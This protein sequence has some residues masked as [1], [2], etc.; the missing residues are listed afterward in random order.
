MKGDLVNCNFTVYPKL[1]TTSF[2]VLF[3]LPDLE[4]NVDR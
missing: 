2:A 3:V 1:D 4:D